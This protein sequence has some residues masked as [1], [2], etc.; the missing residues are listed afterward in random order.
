MLRLDKILYKIQ[1][2]H[3]VQKTYNMTQQVFKGDFSANNLD[4][5]QI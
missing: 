5:G 1:R 3:L 2:P 4:S